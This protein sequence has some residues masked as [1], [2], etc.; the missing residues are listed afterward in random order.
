[1]AT[2]TDHMNLLRLQASALGARVFRNNVG[3]FYTR[4]GTPV[5][6]GLVTGSGDLIGWR[7]E[8]ITPDLIG[9]PVARFLSIEAKQGTGRL[10]KAQRDWRTAVLA[11]GGLAF[12]AYSE[13]D[14]IE[15]LKG[16]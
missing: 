14:V 13:T 15:A 12:T 1:M 8:V 11:A 6:C 9:T 10:E 3:L 4:R 7:T 5:R 16:S 2:S